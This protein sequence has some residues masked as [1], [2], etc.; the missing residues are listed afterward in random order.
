MDLKLDCKAITGDGLGLGGRRPL[1]LDK[2]NRGAIFID[3]MTTL[4]F[5][6]G[7]T[8][9]GVIGGVSPALA[10]EPDLQTQNQD[11][12]IVEMTGDVNLSGT[13]TSADIIY[14]VNY[15]FLVGPEPLPCRAAGDVNCD[16]R[17]SSADIIFL[18]NYVFKSRIPPCDVCSIIETL[19]SLAQKCHNLP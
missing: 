17:V 15:N 13:I 10:A 2:W 7:V 9:V 8:I 4:R 16:G 1:P 18:V 11:T 5:M 12:C 19:Y 6:L 3:T 14:I